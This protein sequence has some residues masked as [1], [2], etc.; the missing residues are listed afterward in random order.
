MTDKYV[1]GEGAL[2]KF[3]SG[4]LQQKFISLVKITTDNASGDILRL[5]KGLTSGAII[6]S[7][8]V[9]NTAIP[10][11]SDVDIGAYSTEYGDELDKDLL[12]DGL[13]LA[14]A[15]TRNSAG[16]KYNPSIPNSQLSIQQLENAIN[17]ANAK[18]KPDV[19]VDLAL[20]LNSTPTAEGTICVEV[21][22]I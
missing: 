19:P 5:N 17:G 9:S 4:S 3:T 18:I 15:V 2:G 21:E 10:G 20:T 6:T 1:L 11:L 12:A 8:K 14:T 13:T 22:Y 7:V 16:E